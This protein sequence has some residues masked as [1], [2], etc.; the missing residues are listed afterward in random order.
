MPKSKLTEAERTE[1]FSK[2]AEQFSK[3]DRLYEREIQDFVNAIIES[4]DNLGPIEIGL[5]AGEVL[6]FAVDLTCTLQPFRHSLDWMSF[7]TRLILVMLDSAKEV[8]RIA[9]EAGVEM[10]DEEAI[11]DLKNSA[12]GEQFDSI[13]FG[14]KTH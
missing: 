6:K 7:A 3:R 2:I 13:D 11:R 14:T 12:S 5:L 8:R 4:D 9:S 10:E 1:L